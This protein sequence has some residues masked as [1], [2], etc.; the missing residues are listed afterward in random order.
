MRQLKPILFT[1]LALA[2]L[3]VSCI[4]P[5]DIVAPDGRNRFPE[6]ALILSPQVLGVPATK[7][8]IA[9]VEGQ[10]ENKLA[11][12]DIFVYRKVEGNNVFFHRYT[13]S[14]SETQQLISGQDYLLESNWRTAKYPDNQGAG[15]EGNTF[16]IYVLANLAVNNRDDI[17]ASPTEAQLRAFVS[18][19][20]QTIEGSYDVVR[21]VDGKGPGTDDWYNPHIADN[22]FLMDGVIDNWTPDNSSS[23]QYFTNK[24]DK[25]FELARA[26][27][28][29]KVTLDFDP[30]FLA[31]LGTADADKLNFTK[32]EYWPGTEVKM[33]EVVT[34]IGNMQYKYA[35]F[36]PV[37]YDFDP[38]GAVS[39]DDLKDFRDANLWE[40]TYRYDFSYRTPA[41]TEGSFKYPYIDTTYSYAFSWDA[42]EA[43]EKAP[44]L[45]ASIIYTRTTRH[46]DA[47]GNLV[48]T[49]DPVKET[50]YYR[51]PL[52]D[53][54]SSTDP[55]TAVERN[56]FYQVDALISSMGATTID[57]EP[58]PVKL[59][60]KVIPWSFNAATDITEVEGVE[61][62]YFSAD[63]T[64]V[65]RGE[66]TQAIR[67]DYFTPK[68]ELINTNPNIY[69]Y[70]PTL[71]NVRVYYVPSVGDTTN[72][73]WRTNP[74]RPGTYTNNNTQWSGSKATSN[75]T[76][77]ITVEPLPD[78][79]GKVYITSQVLANR[80]VKQI[81]F[82]AT[83]TFQIPNLGSDGQPDGTYSYI[84]VTHHYTIKHFPLDN[85]Q[86][87]MGWWSSRWNGV[88]AGSTVTYYRK[89]FYRTTESWTEVTQAVWADGIGESNTDRQ[90]ANSEAN[91]VNGYYATGGQQVTRTWRYSSDRRIISI[92]DN[93]S[94]DGTSIT[95]TGT[96][97]SRRGTTTW[98]HTETAYGDYVEST[99]IN[100]TGDGNSAVFN[101][102]K[103]AHY[104]QLTTTN[105]YSY[106]PNGD[107]GSWTSYDGCEW[108][109]CTE[110]QYNATAAD[111]RRTETSTTIPS[112]GTWVSYSP[113]QAGTIQ[114][115]LYSPAGGTGFYAKVFEADHGGDAATTIHRITQAGGWGTA[116]N[117]TKYNNRNNP[118]MYVIQISKAETG[119]VLGRPVM[120]TTTYQSDDDVVS[121]AFMIASQLGAVSSASYN[122]STAAQHCHT[123]MEVASNGRRFVNW[124]LPT[125]SEIAYISSY[126]SNDDIR[127]QGVFEIVL[128]GAYYYTL[129]GGSAPSN[130]TSGGNGTYVRCIRDLTPEEVAELNSTGTITEATY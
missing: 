91:A 55:V 124:R 3:V 120:N 69:H 48:R 20:K 73:N 59:S 88:E 37:T 114:G 79:G 43:A 34:S 76:V 4:E 67:L 53:V 42:S 65:L 82:D 78:G 87:V 117:V 26:A 22:L 96:R 21:L 45:A 77:S 113:Q 93:Y 105:S 103:Y 46:Y 6:G 18:T 122:A 25:T 89:R 36:L 10:K 19:S 49:D 83:V 2:A 97:T 9:G 125:K 90:N 118:H 92:D 63:T 61:L 56:T 74:N 41:S 84:P 1:V 126:Q 52:V 17:P 75:E 130:N 64:Y 119:V 27:A 15:Y 31:I 66:G 123:Y 11:S 38:E 51:I 58:T 72:I 107:D 44:A 12:L 32:T 108:E 94:W 70:E 80:A 24:T 14:E 121:P 104:Y 112:T 116:A 71:S 40:S 60:Y 115:T 28:K 16:K 129:D 101:L 30:A 111:N 95:F 109:E 54:I 50:N 68:S 86:S 39:P 62:L 29:F 35:N 98:S 110:A 47:S 23:Q 100:G 127:D 128:T 8:T 13:L 7:A 85:I 5:L 106:L 99:S 33:T 102:W 57:I 81:E